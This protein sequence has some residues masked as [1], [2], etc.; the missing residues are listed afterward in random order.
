MLYYV[1]IWFNIRCYHNCASIFISGHLDDFWDWTILE[2]TTK[3]SPDE[4]Q[5]TDDTAIE[6]VSEGAASLSDGIVTTEEQYRQYTPLK[7]SV[8]RNYEIG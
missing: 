1:V 6:N 5:S 2:E 3:V 8:C 4:Q 7:R